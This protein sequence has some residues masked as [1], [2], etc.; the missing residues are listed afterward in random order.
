[1]G[2]RTEAVLYSVM[3]PQATLAITDV[4][5]NVPEATAT[6]SNSALVVTNMVSETIPDTSLLYLRRCLN[7]QL[8]AQR[9]G[10]RNLCCII[11][12]GATMS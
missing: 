1:M 12:D 2:Y 3:E 6:V 9:S 8:S 10:L 11:A 7:R 5:P 4:T